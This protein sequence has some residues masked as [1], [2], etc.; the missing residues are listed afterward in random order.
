[1]KPS[2]VDATN[3]WLSSQGARIGAIGWPSGA[4]L[5]K[6]IIWA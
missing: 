3:M 4:A 5:L 2:S 6:V 1:V